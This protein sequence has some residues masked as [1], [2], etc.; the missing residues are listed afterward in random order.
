MSIVL[1]PDPGIMM[2]SQMDEAFASNAVEL[3]AGPNDRPWDRRGDARA[4]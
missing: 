2:T 1:L 4:H 3:Q